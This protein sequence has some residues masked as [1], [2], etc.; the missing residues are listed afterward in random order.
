MARGRRLYAC[1]CTHV[2][3]GKS[4]NRRREG[5]GNVGLRGG[6]G[7]KSWL[8]KS[9]GTPWLTPAGAVT[10]WLAERAAHDERGME[11]V[12]AGFA[13]GCPLRRSED[14]HKARSASDVT[15]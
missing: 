2:L 7:K 3:G 5:N 11:A 6:K 12:A 10:I 8:G 15:V 1:A 13:A 4:S 9:A 14:E